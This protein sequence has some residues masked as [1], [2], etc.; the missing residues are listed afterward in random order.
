M[1]R[2]IGTAGVP[3]IPQI[4][5]KHPNDSRNNSNGLGYGDEMVAVETNCDNVVVSLDQSRSVN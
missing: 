3:T 2:A 5:Y 4:G 1:G